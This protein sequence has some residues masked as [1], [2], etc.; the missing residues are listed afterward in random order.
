MKEA[1]LWEVGAEGSVEC[2]LCRHRCR[3]AEGTFG[4]CGVRENIDGALYTHAYGELVAANVDPIEKKPL[5]H[6]LPGTMSFSVA[7]MGCN[8]RCGF[9]QNWRISQV[10]AADAHNE[11]GYRM[12]PEQ[13]VENAVRHQCHSIAYTY[14]EPT[15]FFE[16]AY[17]TSVLAKEQGL[18]NIFVTNG[19]MTAEALEAIAPYLDA[20]N[21]DL[22]SFRDEFYRRIC[23]AR[24][25][26]VLDSIRLMKEL[27]I[28]LE[29]TTLV[30]PEEN[31]DM[32]ELRDI[33][34]FIASVDQEIPWHISRFIPDYQFSD[35]QPTPIDLLEKAGAIG[36]EEG[37]R[38]V[39]VD[40]VPGMSR[41]TKCPHCG[42]TLIRRQGVL[43]NE[44]ELSDGRCPYC[45]GNVAG[46][47]KP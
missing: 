12:M 22:K 46:V 10:S 33:A 39:Y 37:L 47:F 21:V 2:F 36:K 7:T 24:L 4:F 19:Y 32:D 30:V 13:I 6:F 28:W 9:C 35:S 38:Y 17:D 15:I 43:I 8:F 40:N 5:Y 11:A 31:D 3:I 45:G 20:C 27:G 18:F 34:R 41:D 26:P 14:T 23:K 29:I 16:Y 42:E 44:Y 1:M 25:D